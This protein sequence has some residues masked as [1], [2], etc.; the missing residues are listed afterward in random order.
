MSRY[1][2]SQ[3]LKTLGAFLIILILLP[4]IISI[5]I[6][7]TEIGSVKDREGVPVKVRL[8]GEDGSERIMEIGWEEYLV[9]ILAEEMPES[10]ELEAMKAQAVLIRS[11]LY[12]ALEDSEDKILTEDY[13]SRSEM[14]KMWG[15]TEFKEY[16]DKYAQAV[17]ET[18]DMVLFYQNAYAWTPFHQSSNGSTR[19]AAEVMGSG[20]YPYLAVKECPLDKEAQDEVQVFTY[21][22]DQIQEACRDFLVAAQGKEQAEKG[23]TFSDFEIQSL[24]SAGYVASLRIGE[25]IC[26]GDQFRDALS[27]PSSAFSFS[28]SD[29]GIKIT[30][31]GKGHGLGM[32]QWTA[33]EMAK[34]GKSFSEILEFFFE[35]TEINQD[36]SEMSLL[37]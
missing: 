6:N 8:A 19:S 32:S 3:K 25:T 5:F 21:S 15:I 16:Y 10:Y 1:Y 4:Y 30:T 31:T 33:N 26:T 36:I 24:D 18:D 14:E 34:G 2:I 27:L 22:Y 7:G 9:G 23:Y 13:M 17:R 12:Q 11:Q 37:S 35:G 20:D 29:S 28:E